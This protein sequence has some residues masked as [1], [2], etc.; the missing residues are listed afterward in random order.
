MGIFT[1]STAHAADVSGFRSARFGATES[2]VMKAIKNDLGV[3]EAN[4]HRTQDAT[5]RVTVL[6][7]KLKAFTPMNLP[8]TM[9][10]VLGY[11]CNCL[12]QVG[13]SWAF[14]DNASVEQ[15]K[16]AMMGVGALVDRF[17]K[18]KWEKDEVVTGRAMG[19]VKDG[20]D[21][22]LVFF[23]GQ[24]KKNEAITL[25]G[26]PVKMSKNAKDP[27]KEDSFAANI[28]EIKTI[29]LSYEKDVVNP[30][31]YKVDVSGF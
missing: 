23:R 5:T 21:N 16:T 12:M 11:K 24:N 28:D 22:A 4:V 25:I 7:V 20:S 8:A 19:E 31:I 29:S 2:E 17:T 9:T 18:M 14:P 3:K 26:A 6:E 1:S 10:Y 30:D 27:K 15:R 13:I